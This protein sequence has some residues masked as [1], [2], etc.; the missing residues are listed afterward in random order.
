MPK[1][2]HTV[3]GN[4]DCERLQIVSRFARMVSQFFSTIIHVDFDNC[5]DIDYQTT[6]FT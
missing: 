2:R 1:F 3:D 5:A 4:R 6:V